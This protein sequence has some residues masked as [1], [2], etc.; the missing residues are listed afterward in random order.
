MYHAL[1]NGLEP[2]DSYLS[3]LPLYS[4]L[5]YGLVNT[6]LLAGVTLGF[7]TQL[8]TFLLSAQYNKKC[9]PASYGDIQSFNPSIIFGIKPW[10]D[11]MHEKLLKV[12]AARPVE[13]QKDFWKWLERKRNTV[14]GR[15]TPLVNMFEKWGRIAE[16][17]TSFF[18]ERMRWVG[19]TCSM[20][21]TEKRELLGLVF[22]GTRGIMVQGWGL[23]HM[24]SYVGLGSGIYT[25][26]DL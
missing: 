10:W 7:G 26:A 22:G 15:S 14:G 16:I 21:T 1:K 18:G 4:R 9:C 3:Y 17:R 5:E 6:F 11:T 2:D 23:L 19:V 12:V 20:M 8:D 25:R 24:S 13:E